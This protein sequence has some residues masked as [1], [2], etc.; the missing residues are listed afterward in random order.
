MCVCVRVCMYEC[1]CECV[2]VSGVGFVIFFNSILYLADLSPRNHW[3][4]YLLSFAEFV[5][6]H[7]QSLT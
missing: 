5:Q 2:Y 6:R 1:V 3:T 7:Q 4:F